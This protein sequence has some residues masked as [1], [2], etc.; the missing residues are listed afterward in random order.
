MQSDH[1]IGLGD[2][3]AHAPDPETDTYIT[4]DS[5]IIRGSIHALDIPIKDVKAMRRIRD[6]VALYLPK[7]VIL[8]I[9]STATVE[10]GDFETVVKFMDY[11]AN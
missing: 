11:K 4:A 10:G 6:G 5:I 2:V 9:P 8:T 3:L 7:N 1:Q